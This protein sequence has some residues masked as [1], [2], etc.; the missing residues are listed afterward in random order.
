[1]AEIEAITA[2]RS[3][4][5]R[6]RSIGSELRRPRLDDRRRKACR[7]AHRPAMAKTA[8]GAR[9]RT[10]TER[11]GPPAEGSPR[12]STKLIVSRVAPSGKTAATMSSASRSRTSRVNWHGDPLAL[13]GGL[14]EGEALH[15][16]GPAA[17]RAGPRSSRARSPRAV[18]AWLRISTSP[19]PA[20]ISRTPE[21]LHQVGD[22]GGEP[23]APG[24]E[25]RRTTTRAG[26]V[27]ANSRRRR[28]GRRV[29]AVR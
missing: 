13:A 19:P 27:A 28:P 16:Q 25:R 8:P 24:V 6:R 10:A 7:I 3:E 23:L 2:A 15:P 17:E 14:V 5:A 29:E 22:A 26:S 1:M 21:G 20:S 11:G 9:A 4:W 18:G 12:G